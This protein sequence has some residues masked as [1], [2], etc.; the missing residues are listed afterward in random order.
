MKGNETVVTAA[1]QNGLALERTSDEMMNSVTV[2]T[3]AVT[4]N[5]LALEHLRTT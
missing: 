1:V 3:A 5:G 4:R 2:V